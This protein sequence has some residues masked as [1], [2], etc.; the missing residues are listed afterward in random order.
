[1]KR[2]GFKRKPQKPLK[3]TPLKKKGKTG[4]ANLNANKII[5]RILEGGDV[6]YC[7][8]QLE[9]CMGNWPLQVVHR[10]P[11]AWYKG[12]VELLSSQRQWIIG[13]Q[14]CHEQLDRRTD[15]SKALTEEVFMR[16]RGG[17]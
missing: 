2:T 13:C 1:M 15:E 10:H 17:E 7:Q 4:E 5:R 9:G 11:R 12:S 14:K 3:R 16:I 6:G 8:I